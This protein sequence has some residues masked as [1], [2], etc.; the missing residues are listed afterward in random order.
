V[1]VAEFIDVVA[2]S[3]NLG[4]HK[5][6]PT[7]Y[8]NAVRDAHLTPVESCFVGHDARELEGARQVGMATVAVRYDR[9]ARADYYAET[10]LDLLNVP[11]FQEH[12]PKADDMS[13]NVSSNNIEAVF[14]DVG[15]TLRIVIA[16]ALFQAQ[17][18]QQLMSLVGEHGPEETFFAQLDT[19]WKAYRKWSFEDLT[20]ASEKELWTR[21]MLPDHTADTIAP[22]S[23]RLTRLWRD[24][25]GRRVP[26]P[27]VKSVV[28]ELSKRGYVLGIIANTITETEIPD[29]L[30][31]DGLG[32]YFASVV[33][34]SKVRNRKPGPEIYWEAARRVGIAPAHCAYVGD[35]PLRDVVGTRRAGFGMIIILMEAQ[36]LAKE[37]PTGE[38]VPDRII[39]TCSELLHIFPPRPTAPGAER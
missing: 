10:L 35:N 1:G 2:C 19:R 22:L 28:I 23:G 25:D 12:T 8:L 18:R 3:T 14:L 16:D 21:F 29:W 4:V 32:Q 34:S 20:E 33:L 37:P 31:A 38:N 15:N 7:I 11:I 6:D 24:K 39:E 13:Q 26:R 17:A 5:P 27:D 36:K 9:H 30:E